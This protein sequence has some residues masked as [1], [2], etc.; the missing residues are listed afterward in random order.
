MTKQRKLLE[1]LNAAE[2]CLTETRRSLL[3][4]F[5]LPCVELAKGIT[6]TLDQFIY[7]A[8]QTKKHVR[9]T[10][11]DKR[12]TTCDLVTEQQRQDLRDAGRGHLL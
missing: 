7:P 9:K 10:T 6:E 4:S 8:L 2:Q 3:N 11:V 5:P 12:R 1:A